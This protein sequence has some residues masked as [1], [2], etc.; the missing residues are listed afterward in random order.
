MAK[1]RTLDCLIDKE[2]YDFLKSEKDALEEQAATGNLRNLD[3]VWLKG[4][5][6]IYQKIYNQQ[7]PNIN[8]RTCI[9]A[10]VRPLLHQIHQFENK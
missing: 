7:R 6:L 10:F 3:P 2:E 9:A 4:A 1:D 5:A 8:C